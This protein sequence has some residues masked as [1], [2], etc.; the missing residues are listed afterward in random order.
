MSSRLRVGVILHGCGRTYG[1]IMTASCHVLAGF[2]D[3]QSAAPPVGHI[4]WLRA[5]S[6][7]HGLWVRRPT[8]GKY[9]CRRS[10]SSRATASS[11]LCLSLMK[12][13][14]LPRAALRM[15]PLAVKVRHP[16]PSGLREVA[17]PVGAKQRILH[18]RFRTLTDSWV[19][20]GVLLD[21]APSTPGE[22]TFTRM[23][24]LPTFMVI[25]MTSSVDRVNIIRRGSPRQAP[26]ASMLF[27]RPLVTAACPAACRL[28]VVSA[29]SRK[30]S[31]RRGRWRA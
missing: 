11:H 28:G 9:P 26:N 3:W 31:S 19:H 4:A 18:R 16:R 30:G 22:T 13:L 7:P 5:L 2:E 29:A 15:A 21:R 10:C 14:R 25:S 8:D 12:R 24:A 1:R 23:L 6:A 20:V 17:A 27:T